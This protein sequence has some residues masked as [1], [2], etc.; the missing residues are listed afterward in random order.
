MDV[1][2]RNDYLADQDLLVLINPPNDKRWRSQ[3]CTCSDPSVVHDLNVVARSAR[4]FY[5]TPYIPQL[6]LIPADVAV[7]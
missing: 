5:S 3:P 4:S 1:R 7:T 6:F 2:P